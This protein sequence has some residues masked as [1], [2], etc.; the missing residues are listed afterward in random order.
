MSNPRNPISNDIYL[1]ALN[2]FLMRYI[3]WLFF[4]IA[5]EVITYFGVVLLFVF[6]FSLVIFIFNHF[7]LMVSSYHV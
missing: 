5:I 3:R 2:I 1:L 7:Y 6:L 4:R